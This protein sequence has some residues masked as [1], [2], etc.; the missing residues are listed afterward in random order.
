VSHLSGSAP[1][2]KLE[3]GSR[4]HRRPRSKSRRKGSWSGFIRAFY[5]VL[6]ALWGYALGAVVLML[7]LRSSGGIVPIDGSLLARVAP[8]ALL[9]LLG[10]VVS[11]A[12]YRQARRRHS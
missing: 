1:I 3:R 6:A 12:A 5:F 9:A 8:G 7:A 10:G 2:D 11:A 4:R